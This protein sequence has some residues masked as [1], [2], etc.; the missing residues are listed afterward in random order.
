MRDNFHYGRI[1]IDVNDIDI[2]GVKLDN[3]KIASGVTINNGG[4]NTIGPTLTLTIYADEIYMTDEVK[5]SAKEHGTHV[6]EVWG[7]VND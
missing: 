6:T 1:T 3:L 7:D 4:P 2:D 5:Q